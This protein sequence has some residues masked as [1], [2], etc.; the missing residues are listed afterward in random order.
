MRSKIVEVTMPKN[1]PDLP[2]LV[3]SPDGQRVKV[4]KTAFAEDV[5]GRYVCNDWDE[6]M[7]S[8][9]DGGFPFDVIVIGAG[10]FGA[11]CAEK[12]YRRGTGIGLRVLLFDAG[13]FEL[14]GHIQNLPPLGGGLG[15][16]DP[17]T[18]DDGV[19]NVVW[20]M[21]WITDTTVTRSQNTVPGRPGTGPGFPGL[22][23]AVGGRSLYWGGWS[24]ELT[25][26]DLAA[27]PADVRPFLT[28]PVP[29]DANNWS[30]Y[31]RTAEEIGTATVTDFMF[32]TPF[33]N[34]L[35]ADLQKA[36]STVTG[37]RAVEEAPLAVQ[38]TAP[39]SG[40]FAFDKYS[41]APTV[42]DAVRNDVGT[43]SGGGD[44]TRR[45]FL[46]P[47]TQVLRLNVTAGAVT[48][49]DVSTVSTNGALQNLPVPSGCAVVLA[50]G[51]IEA[52]RLA[53]T[54]LGVGDTRFGSPRLGNLMAHLRSNITVK[55]KRTAL[56]LPAGAPSDLET[57][58]FLL[59]GVA[60]GRRFHF[61]VVAAAVG[62]QNPEQNLFQQIP[63]IDILD[64]IRA[65]QDPAWITIVLRGIGEMAGDTSLTPNPAGNWIDLSPETDPLFGQR[66]AFVRLGTT[67]NDAATWEAMDIAAFDLA[68][69]LAGGPGAAAAGDIQYLVNGQWTGIRPTVDPATGGPWRDGIGTTHHE[70]GTLFMGSSGSSVTD[71]VGRFHNVANAY[72]AGPALF[73]TVGSANPSL[74]GL[75]LAR[76]TAGAIIAARAPSGFTSLSLDPADW[77]MIAA[78]GTNPVMN[79]IG[80]I[81][82]TFGGYGLYC[83][84]KQQFGDFS[85]WLEWRET[86]AGDNSG[87][88]IRIP[89]PAGIPA[90]DALT[91]ADQQGHEIQID[92]VGAGNPLGQAIHQTGAIYGLQAP[93]SIP[94]APVGEWNTYLIE[95]TGNR[96]RVALNGT[97][98]NDY[99]STR[100]TSGFLALQVHGSR[101]AIRNLRIK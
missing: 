56:G 86:A 26:D 82:Q 69:T 18:V 92:D 75:A 60:G 15:A 4:Q 31:Q 21:P 43:N 16:P 48:S 6:V 41:T 77:T 89:D 78:P 8:L 73:P 88:Y 45:I 101:L 90:T 1:P 64:Q 13:S 81:L 85:L 5:L 68:D 49:I 23:Y 83:Y 42:I 7:A 71:S 11:Y 94:T 24:P 96:I 95:A 66:R 84:T 98:V 46:V 76:R 39:A 38:G 57:T 14:P 29:G 97:P 99:T 61:Q 51:T 32:A 25:G 47:R 10:M 44:V 67:G 65:N 2:L 87:V 27:W 22:A 53:L 28:Q 59:R 50:N 30:G 20:G 34:T 37:L 9:A 52:T 54:S 91:R 74:T 62:S 12:L 93:S 58:A 17:R 63:D 55:I 33:H 70:A 35:L 79:R 40:L 80:S 72:V 19:K 36:A 3:A 100:R